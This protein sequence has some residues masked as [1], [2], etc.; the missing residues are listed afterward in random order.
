MNIEEERLQEAPAGG[1]TK[2]PTAAPKNRVTASK[3]WCF[4]LNNW[5]EEELALLST[6]FSTSAKLWIIGKEVGENGTPHLQGFVEFLDKSRPLESVKNKR[7]HWEKT[8]G[9]DQENWVYCSKEG[10]FLHGGDWP[11]PKKPLKLIQSESFFPWQ[12]RV[13]EICEQEPDDRTIHWWWDPNGNVGKTALTKF[14]CATKG[15]IIL[16][17]KKNDILYCAAEFESDIYIFDIE[18]SLEGFVPYGALEKIKNGCFMCAKYESK[19]I[20]RNSPHVWIFANFEPDMRKLS[21]DRWDVR[22]IT[23]ES[24]TF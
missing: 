7:I 1:N 9:S 5:T 4:T 24:E 8:K 21:N 11:K 17:G 6:H 15:A 18:R 12:K 10:D 22:I 14:L 23:R 13:I 20:V 2:T 3:R 19:P 16:E